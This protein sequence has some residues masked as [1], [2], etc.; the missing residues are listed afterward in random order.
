MTTK[1]MNTALALEIVKN[2]VIA[3]DY[4][5]NVA[6]HNVNQDGLVIAQDVKN[7]EDVNG[8]DIFV[9]WR[10]KT[11]TTK[12]GKAAAAMIQFA[13]GQLAY[14]AKQKAIETTATHGPKDLALAGPAVKK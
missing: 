12:F 3:A 11:K 14:E 10:T 13:E 2:A 4:L 8:G 6:Q 9:S 1:G 7:G 5:E